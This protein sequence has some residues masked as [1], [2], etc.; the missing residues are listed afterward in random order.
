W[1]GDG[2]SAVFSSDLCWDEIDTEPP[3]PRRHSRMGTHKAE[4]HRQVRPGEIPADLPMLL[5][6]YADKRIVRLQRPVQEIEELM[7]LG[8]RHKHGCPTAPNDALI[9]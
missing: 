6:Q 2:S 7:E 4:S 9:E 8:I 1:R 3:E 5:V